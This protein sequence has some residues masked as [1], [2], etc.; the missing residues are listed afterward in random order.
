VLS[1]IHNNHDIPPCVS[2][3]LSVTWAKDLLRDMNQHHDDRWVRSKQAREILHVTSRTLALW[4][5][6]GQV[7]T[8][9]LPG[10]ARRQHRLY[11]VSVFRSGAGRRVPPFFFG[12]FRNF[13]FLLFLYSISHFTFLLCVPHCIRG[14]VVRYISAPT[15][16]RDV[17]DDRSPPFFLARFEISHFNNIFLLCVPHCIRG[18]IVRYISV[19]TVEEKGKR[20]SDTCN[21][22]H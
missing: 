22:R 15:G 11:D 2:K 20:D 4:A 7:P 5:R 21:S 1:V 19:P 10:R 17:L 14:P 13:T 16:C 8:M 3:P 12:P 18:P 6:K 9:L